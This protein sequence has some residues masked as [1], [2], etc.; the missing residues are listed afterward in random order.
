VSAGSVTVQNSLPPCTNSNQGVLGSDGHLRGTVHCAGASDP[1]LVA[2]KVD[3]KPAALVE[4]QGDAY[5]SQI[6]V[7]AGAWEPGDTLWHP[8]ELIVDPLNLFKETDETNNRWAGQVRMVGPDLS[9]IDGLSRV[10]DAQGTSVTSA[11]VGQPLTI[12]TGARVGGRY[13]S[14]ELSATSEAFHFTETLAL[15]E[16][17]IY[18]P[19]LGVWNWTPSAPGDFSIMF[20]VRILS[21]EAQSDSTNDAITRVL[22]VR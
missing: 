18:G 14:A 7:D 9:V 12:V 6:D 15:D 16:C 21:G 10:I 19:P 1:F 17:D 5:G 8:V 13:A 22:S 20:R 3:G 2:V 11:S 4:V